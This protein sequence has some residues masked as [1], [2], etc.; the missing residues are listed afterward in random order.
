MTEE[1]ILVDD[2]APALIRI[3]VKTGHG[4]GKPVQKVVEER[5]DVIAFMLKHTA[6]SR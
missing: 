5:A 3:S 4:A 1:L 2:A 6:Q